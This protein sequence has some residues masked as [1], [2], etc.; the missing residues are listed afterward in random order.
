MLTNPL[1]WQRQT[2]DRLFSAPTGLPHA[3]LISG[4]EGIGKRQFARLV[5]QALLCEQLGRSSHPCGACLSCHWFE[6]ETHPDFKLL[7]PDSH[8]ADETDG[9]DSDQESGRGRGKQGGKQISVAQVRGLA[10]FTDLSAH[11]CGRKVVMLHPAEDLNLSAANALLKTLE[12]PP[13]ETFFLMVCHRAHRILPTVRSRCRLMPMRIPGP[14]ESIPW[15]AEQGVKDPLLALSVAGFAPLRALEDMRADN[16]ERR[17]IFLRRLAN[18]TLDPIGDAGNHDSTELPQVLGW[19]H[20]WTYDLVANRLSGRTRYNPDF[21]EPLRHISRQADI[22]QLGRYHRSLV[23][24]QSRLGHPLNP[25]LV[26]EYL[27]LSY[28]RSIGSG[29]E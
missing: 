16:L 12:E 2:W 3:L 1:P 17:K 6:Q 9:G 21:A 29:R 20:Q 8:A 10:G 19:L 23:A 28:L 7:Q 11:R 25:R 27:F 5:A 22:V 15:L 18:G 14:A 13:R 4:P 26:F 24:Y